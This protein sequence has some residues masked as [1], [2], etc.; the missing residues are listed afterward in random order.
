MSPNL[1][2]LLAPAVIGFSLAVVAPAATPLAAQTPAAAAASDAGLYLTI[3][4]NPSTGLE[5]RGSRYGVN[6]GFYPTILKADGQEDGE[7]T[8][9]VRIGATAYL[10]R[11]G[12][13]PYL[14]PSL[15]LSL[16]DD[17][18]NGVLTDV[19]VRLPFTRRAAFRLGVGVLTTFDGEVRVNPTVGFDVRLGGAK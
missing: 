19:G 4:R 1:R 5:W 13:T 16:D 8:N 7:N 10:R 15:V 14:S 12:W 11:A 18:D 6:A 9:F 3:F 2:R 17:W